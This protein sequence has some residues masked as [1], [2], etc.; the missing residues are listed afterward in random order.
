MRLELTAEE[1]TELVAEKHGQS[2]PGRMQLAFD[3]NKAEYPP[4]ADLIDLALVGI[5]FEFPS[6]GGIERPIKPQKE[7]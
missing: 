1:L 2:G 5:V 6:N 4:H 3:K 7:A